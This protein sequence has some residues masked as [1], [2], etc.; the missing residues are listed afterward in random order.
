MTYGSD[1]VLFKGVYGYIHRVSLENYTRAVL[2]ARAE[3][4][5]NPFERVKDNQTNGK[6]Y[7]PRKYRYWSKKE[8]NLLRKNRREGVEFKVIAKRLGRS[9][10]A[11]HRK[12]DRL[13]ITNKRS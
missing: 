4:R 9:E 13:G 1:R 11:C 5:A 10:M 8:V 12:A 6:P 7:K 3:Y 2:R